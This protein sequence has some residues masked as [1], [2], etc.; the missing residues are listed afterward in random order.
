[1]SNDDLKKTVD[2]LEREERTK[3]A[4]EFRAAVEQLANEQQLTNE[5][6]NRANR[7]A[8]PAGE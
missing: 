6:G 1:M 2:E 5:Q 8:R 7:F 3:L 4:A